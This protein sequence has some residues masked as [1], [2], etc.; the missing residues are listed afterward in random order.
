V[1]EV[2]LMRRPAPK[3]PRVG[4]DESRCKPWVTLGAIKSWSSVNF[5]KIKGNKCRERV[6]N[7]E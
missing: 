5:P 7:D 2:V 4:A 3:T 6:I 1:I